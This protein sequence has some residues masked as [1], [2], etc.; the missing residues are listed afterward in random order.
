MH[1]KNA[2]FP[3]SNKLLL[4]ILEKYCAALPQ[5][6]ACRPSLEACLLGAYRGEVLQTPALS[7]TDWPPRGKARHAVSLF[8]SA[9]KAVSSACSP[10]SPFSVLV[11][12]LLLGGQSCGSSTSWGTA[13]SSRNPFV[14]LQLLPAE[15]LCRHLVDSHSQILRRQLVFSQHDKVSTSSQTIYSSRGVQ[16]LFLIFYKCFSAFSCL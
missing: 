9:G 7:A 12:D 2:C 3:G 15:R 5:C 10:F 11:L 16:S 13:H 1:G 4:C 14:P 6:R 8:F